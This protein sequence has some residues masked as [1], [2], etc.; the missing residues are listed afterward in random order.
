MSRIPLRP[1][2]RILPAR[3]KGEN[4]D[5]IERENIRRRHEEM[6]DR[7]RARAEGRLLVLSAFFFC[8]F[9]VIGVRMGH[10]ATSEAVE[11]I[12]TCG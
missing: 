3:D 9:G 8:A 4:P 12:A 10:L 7:S 6:Q 1:L 11:P 5:I 2:A